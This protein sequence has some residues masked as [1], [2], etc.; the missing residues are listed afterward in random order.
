MDNRALLDAIE[1]I[2]DALVRRAEADRT[3][4]GLKRVKRTGVLWR[5]IPVLSA[6]LLLA[7]GIAAGVIIAQKTKQ[8]AQ[9][10]S[11][12]NN[13]QPGSSGN[14]APIGSNSTAEPSGEPVVSEDILLSL[15]S[16]LTGEG[17]NANMNSLERFKEIISRYRVNGIGVLDL[18]DNDTAHFIYDY[19]GSFSVTFLRVFTA[20]YDQYSGNRPSLASGIIAY[21]P[22]EGLILPFGIEFG[23]ELIDVLR[24]LGVNSDDLSNW[25]KQPSVTLSLAE[26]KTMSLKLN[27]FNSSDNCEYSL[28]FEA[29][30]EPDPPYNE[31]NHTLSLV[32]SRLPTND[33]TWN[34]TVLTGVR[35]WQWEYINSPD[36][37]APGSDP[38]QP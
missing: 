2:D 35:M 25:L 4:T 26:T 33:S 28:D 32:F 27:Y 20:T 18:S 6:V 29:I 31:A 38:S 30:F 21:A 17:L 5:A 12:G 15:D 10:G 7:A 23:D 11:S 19:S 14:N 13:A 22:V 8:H 34:G 3:G 9:P 16:F 36:S 24:I 37:T 1:G